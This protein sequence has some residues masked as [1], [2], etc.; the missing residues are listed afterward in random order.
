[1]ITLFLRITQGLIPEDNANEIGKLLGDEEAKELNEEVKALFL[2][3]LEICRKNCVLFSSV[4]S[5]N[6]IRKMI[7]RKLFDLIPVCF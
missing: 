4:I 2:M 6:G 1:M 5:K 3:K 7:S